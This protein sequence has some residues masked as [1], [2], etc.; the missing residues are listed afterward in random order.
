M[1]PDATRAHFHTLRAHSVSRLHQQVIPLCQQ[2]CRWNSCK[3][4]YIYIYIRVKSFG[5]I[6]LQQPKSDAIR[7]ISSAR[8]KLPTFLKHWNMHI[9][10]IYIYVYLCV[11]LYMYIYIYI[12]TCECAWVLP[13]R[14]RFLLK[15]IESYIPKSSPNFSTRCSCCSGVSWTFPCVASETMGWEYSLRVGVLWFHVNNHCSPRCSHCARSPTIS[16]IANTIQ[17][18]RGPQ[19]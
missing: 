6:K 8:P 5:N 17:N 1:L 14:M 16:I 13:I 11:Y 3:Y 2:V 10:Y 4:I 12:Y 7:S 15:S 18:V 19:L 9:V